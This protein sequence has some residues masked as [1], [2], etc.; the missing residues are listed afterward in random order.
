MDTMPAHQIPVTD[1]RDFHDPVVTVTRT[2]EGPVYVVGQMGENIIAV[3]KPTRV[4]VP[5]FVEDDEMDERHAS[6]MQVAHDECGYEAEVH[7]VR[8]EHGGRV[9]D[10]VGM[11]LAPAGT[12]VEVRPSGSGAAA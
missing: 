1:E 2:W 12:E 11:F 10:L 6:L 5:F 9:R 3:N 4:V 8:V 7:V